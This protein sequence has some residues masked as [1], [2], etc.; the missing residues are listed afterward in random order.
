MSVLIVEKQPLIS[1]SGMTIPID[2]FDFMPRIAVRLDI[3]ECK[4]CGR[5][6]KFPDSGSC[7]GCGA[8]L[9]V[10]HNAR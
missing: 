5:E 4:Y 9:S 8:P 6:Q 1:P 2:F 7:R 3:V 10:R